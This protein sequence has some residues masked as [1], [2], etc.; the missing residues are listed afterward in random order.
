[1]DGINGQD[2]RTFSK[3]GALG[4]LAAAIQC[5]HT[6]DDPGDDEQSFHE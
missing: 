1:V 6:A 2:D 5:S 3:F 4:Q